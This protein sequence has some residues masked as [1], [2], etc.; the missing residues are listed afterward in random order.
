MAAARES[1][2]RAGLADMVD[3]RG[4]PAL[5]TLPLLAAEGLA[6]F[7]MV[8]IDAGKRSDPDYLGWALELSGPGTVIVADDAV[9]GGEAAGFHELLAAEPC[10]TA[11]TV[12]T[13]G[14][15]G[16]TVALVE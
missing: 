8:F 6:P 16:F 15:D 7:D 12:Q 14:W 2:A 5:Y 9:R 11:T 10:L 4:G 1:V 13:V 3:V